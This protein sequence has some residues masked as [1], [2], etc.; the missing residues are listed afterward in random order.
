M[1]NLSRTSARFIA[2]FKQ[3]GTVEQYIMVAE[4]HQ[5]DLAYLAITS[6]ITGHVFSCTWW[7]KMWLTCPRWRCP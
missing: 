2:F 1:T 6:A 7:L 5:L 3:R 4:R